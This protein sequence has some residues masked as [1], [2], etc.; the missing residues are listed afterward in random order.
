[1]GDTELLTQLRQLLIK[2]FSDGELRTLCFDL[3]VEYDD[4][5]GQGKADK[6]RELVT[7][8]DQHGRLAD[9][10]RFG[11]QSRPDV[12]WPE[13]GSAPVAKSSPLHSSLPRRTYARFIMRPQP[14]A[15]IVSRLSGPTAGAIIVGLSGT[16]KTTL[17]REIAQGCIE[18]KPSLPEFE[19]ALWIDVGKLPGIPNLHGILN[20]ISYAL[21]SPGFAQLAEDEQRRKIERLLERYKILLIIDNFEVTID[22]A[23]LKWLLSIP[24]P[25][26]ALIATKEDREDFPR[27]LLIK[28]GGLSQPESL[29]FIR[30]Q[31]SAARQGEQ[32]RDLDQ[33]QPLI[34]STEG[35][36][37]ALD[38]CLRLILY[39]HRSIGQVIEDLCNGRVK[40]LDGIL[41]QAWSLLG[42]TA[43]LILSL[44]A[45]FAFGVSEQA[46]GETAEV[47]GVRL[48]AALKRLENLS[49]IDVQHP[50]LAQLPRYVVHS[51]VRT[52]IQS[53]LRA[54]P[55]TERERRVSWLEW[56]MRT[57]AS[58][59]WMPPDFKKIETLQVDEEN[60]YAAI[61]WAAEQPQEDEFMARAVLGIARG[62]DHYYYVRGLWDRKERVD[63][64]RIKAA[65]ALGDLQEEARSLAQHI[66]LL[67]RKGDV[68]Q[69]GRWLEELR[70]VEQKAGSLSP[71]VQTQVHHAYAF[72]FMAEGKYD[73]AYEILEQCRRADPQPSPNLVVANLH[74]AATCLYKQQC[75]AEAKAAFEEALGEAQKTDY[76]RSMIYCRLHLAKIALDEGELAK[77][78]DLLAECLERARTLGDLRYIGQ[79]QVTH[80]RLYARWNNYPSARSALDEAELLYE[81]LG[82]YD[83]RDILVRAQQEVDTL[84]RIFTRM[85]ENIAAVKTRILMLDYDG[86][87]APFV[88]LRDQAVPYPGVRAALADILAEGRT[89]LVIVSGRAIKDLKPLLGLERLPEIWGNHGWERLLPDGAYQGPEI[90]DR[91]KESFAEARSRT[92]AA[93]L[94]VV[95]IDLERKPASLALHWRRRDPQVVDALQAAVRELWEPLAESAKL[96]IKAFDG[97]LELGLPDKDKGAAVRTILSEASDDTVA[98]YLGDDQTDE[99]A[100]RAIAERGYG[101]LVRPDYRPTAATFWLKPPDEL[102]EFLKHWV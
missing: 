67:C 33:F 58:G 86:T 15:E 69:A 7:H 57:V 12:P 20:A 82:L 99:D 8:M 90:E 1:M 72:H 32:D 66:Q 28:L 68:E 60:L 34:E 55:Q 48:T 102:L 49:L 71:D 26:K 85:L 36:P 88:V 89:R 101:I 10:V 91:A 63:R 73:R 70:A 84:K 51:L 100:F 97:G 87:L 27:A 74:W 13:W 23:V 5:P 54:Q 44:A 81:R 35:N 18:G 75:Y 93:D 79:I 31:L 78:A 6:A 77:A 9:L 29:K 94:G 2:R 95:P 53:K 47:E 24:E 4:L 65:R 80:A 61:T 11:R 76:K 98:A 42:E 46:L 52:F 3:G 14:F 83:D 41:E 62:I 30:Q 59:G 21:R 45:L 19:A 96:T 37:K 17:A 92:L 16:G 40:G 56:A 64:M 25:S 38:I 43:R 50:D 39:E 22:S